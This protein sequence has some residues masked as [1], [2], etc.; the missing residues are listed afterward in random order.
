MES[1]TPEPSRPEASAGALAFGAVAVG[2]FGAI[3]LVVALLVSTNSSEKTSV[4]AG[5]VTVTLQY[6]K[7]GPG[8]VTATTGGGIDVVNRDAMQHNLAV[9][10]SP[11]ATPS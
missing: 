10:N 6:P 5:A 9:E 8:T 11:L 7:V 1:H 4:G 3:A 2:V